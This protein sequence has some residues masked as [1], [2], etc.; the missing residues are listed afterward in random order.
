MNDQELST[1]LHRDAEL[2]GA[3]SPDLLDQLG[4]RRQHQ[5]RQRTGLVA[6]VLGVIV[7]AGGIPLGQSYFAGPDGGTA[8][9]P[10]TPA[11]ATSAPASSAPATSAPAAPSG[12]PGCP[13]AATLFALVPDRPTGVSLTDT[14]CSGD[15]AVIG[16]LGPTYGQRVQLFQY[17]DGSW[18]PA[19]SSQACTAG[20]LPADIE[21]GVCDAG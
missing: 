6:A 2:A 11:P 20:Q 13:D 7:V 18:R 21:P 17:V 5:R 3:P 10:S 12:S 8:T 14:T 15:W 9:D 1:A 19:D 16:V 4:R